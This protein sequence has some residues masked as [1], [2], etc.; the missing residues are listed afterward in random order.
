MKFNYD[1]DKKANL[2]E[3]QKNIVY[4]VHIIQINMLIKR[5]QGII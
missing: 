1:P 3:L 4:M 2:Q 5:S